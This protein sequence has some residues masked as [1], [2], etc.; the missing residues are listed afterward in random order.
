MRSVFHVTKRFTHHHA[1]KQLFPLYRGP[2]ITKISVYQVALPLHEGA[3]KWSGGNKV[4]AFDAT[5]VR[6]STNSGV[7]GYGECTPLGPVYLPSYA[8]G[9][10]TGIATLAPKLIHA[11]PT[12][13]QDVNSIMDK[14]LKG[15][16]YVKSAIDM[17]CW[18]ILGKVAKLPVCELLG[19]RFTD[20]FK[21]YRAISQDTPER[22]A[23]NVEDY[24]NQGY[25]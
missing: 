7:Y 9:V 19:G 2:K 17:A 24:V 21:L 1:S 15:H 10:R 14:N 3:Y 16:P 8:E 12:R 23:K 22:M 20:Q 13:I 25:R 6:I 18:D 5:V 11:D 4:E